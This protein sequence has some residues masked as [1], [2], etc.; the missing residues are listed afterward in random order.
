MVTLQ[1]KAV[2]GETEL[3]RTTT[4]KGTMPGTYGGSSGIKLDESIRDIHFAR[5]GETFDETHIHIRNVNKRTVV[6]KPETG[7]VDVGIFRMTVDFA[8]GRLKSDKG[9]KGLPYR[10]EAGRC[11]HQAVITIDQHRT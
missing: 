2:D 3:Q 11:T 9:S 8:Q 7:G 10:K 4:K 5:T 6:S 1:E